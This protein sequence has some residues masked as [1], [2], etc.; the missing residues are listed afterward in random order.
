MNGSVSQR[1]EPMLKA[2]G[3]GPRAELPRY[4]EDVGLGSAEFL[5]A[6]RRLDLMNQRDLLVE[7]DGFPEW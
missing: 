1:A 3:V 2:L 4:S 7:G 6:A 5:V